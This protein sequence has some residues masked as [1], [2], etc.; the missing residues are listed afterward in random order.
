[1]QDSV[2]ATATGTHSSSG[3]KTPTRRAIVL[4]S[5]D[6]STTPAASTVKTTRQK[7]V[8]LDPPWPVLCIINGEASNVECLVLAIW[9]GGAT[10]RTKD[11]NLLTEFDLQFSS[12]PRPVRR[13]CKRSVVRGNVM[14][15]E[16]K[17]ETLR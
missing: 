6:E 14:D 11:V 16:F 8:W 13:R 4:R 1:M 7:T 17:P 5:A 15:V 10:L 3:V 12:G 2:A 9:D